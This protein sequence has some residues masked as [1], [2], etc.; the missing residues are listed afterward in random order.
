[1]DI[2]ANPISHISRTS[3]MIDELVDKISTLKRIVLVTRTK[4]QSFLNQ[5]GY[6]E[7]S[8]VANLKETKTTNI[9]MP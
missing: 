9:R 2:V 5:L 3:S 7:L 4:E 1:M 8:G 6:K